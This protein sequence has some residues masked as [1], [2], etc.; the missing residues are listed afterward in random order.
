[1]KFSDLVLAEWDKTFKT[2]AHLGDFEVLQLNLIKLTGARPEGRRNLVAVTRDGNVKWVAEIPTG[3]PGYGY[4][5]NVAYKGKKLKGW[6]G[7]SLFVEI[8]V[9]TGKIVKENVAD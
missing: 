1:M 3:D 5:N 8:D 6:Y 4:F 9:E 7:G 2:V